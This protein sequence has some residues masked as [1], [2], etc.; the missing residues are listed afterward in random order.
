MK[1]NY[2]TVCQNYD[3]SEN[4]VRKEIKPEDFQLS[5]D[6][7]K[8][9]EKCGHQT[10]FELIHGNIVFRSSKIL[11]KYL[12]QMKKE[13]LLLRRLSSNRIANRRDIRR[14]K[15][16]YKLLEKAVYPISERLVLR[17]KQE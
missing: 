14:I 12:H 2:Y 10:M 7:P 11:E 17:E 13:Y 15:H 4:D 8:P 5:L 6:R 1:A 3:C 9:C 16:I